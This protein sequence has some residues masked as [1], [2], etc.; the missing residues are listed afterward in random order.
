MSV[1]FPAIAWTQ[2]KKR[3]DLL[4]LTGVVLYLAAFIGAMGVMHPEVTPETMII[5]ATGTLAFFM[6]HVILAIGPLAR[7]NRAFLPLLYNRR[8]LGV[9]MFLLALIHGGFSIFQFHGLGDQIALI[10][11]FT[12][13]T[14]YQSWLD[15]PFQV[16]GFIALFILFLMA[17]SSHDYW[18]KNLTPRV[19]KSLHMGVYVAWVLI[20][21]H[22]FLGVLQLEKDPGLYY[23]VVLGMVIIPGLHVAGAMFGAAKPVAIGSRSEDGFVAVLKADEI[24]LDRA[25]MASIDDQD[26]AIYRYENK[27]SAVSNLCRHQ[28]GPLSEGKVIDGC[29]T[30]PWHGWQYKPEDGCSPPPFEEKIPTFRVRIEAGVVLVHPEPLAPGTFTEPAILEA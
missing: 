13:N 8:H 30:C 19:W 16:L 1:G 18:L 24:P 20:I 29:I 15:F 26:V 14:D 12:S 4:I 28:Q 10:S 25:V 11:V 3:Y 23:T 17:G 27:V 5:R 7:L 2:S 6:L 22:V 21:F 9:S